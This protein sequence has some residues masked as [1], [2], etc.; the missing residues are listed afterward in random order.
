M[1]L[2]SE[3][4]EYF[5]T[6][7]IR[8]QANRGMLTPDM[9]TRIAMAVASWYRAQHGVMVSSTPRV[10]I[11]KDTRLSGYLLEPALTA[12][13]IAAGMDVMLLGPLP[14]SA[15]S[16]LVPSTRSTLGI[17]I[18][19]SHNPYRD[20]GIK[21]FGPRGHKL[22]TADECAI[23]AY[24]REPSLLY[25]APPD[26][27]GRAS[28]LEDARGRYIEMIKHRLPSGLRLDGLRIVLDA[29]HGASYHVGPQIL[30]ELGADVISAG[31]H[32]SGTN[33]NDY[34]GSTFPEKMQQMVKMHQADIGMALDGDA[35][36][37]IL[38][39]EEGEVIRGEEC[40][41]ALAVFFAGS[42]KPMERGV[43]TTILA[44]RALDAYLEP[45]GIPVL[46]VPVGDRPVAEAMRDRG[47]CLGGEPSGHMM[48][49]ADA[50]TGDGLLAGLQAVAMMQAY[51]KTASACL[52][53]FSLFPQI[54][55]HVSYDGGLNTEA[56][57]SIED[58]VR[59]GLPADSRVILRPSGTEPILR[60]TL[61]GKDRGILERTME[62]TV[63][64]LL[65]AMGRSLDG[66]GVD[67]D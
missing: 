49:D 23:E 11:A 48:F 21:I 50:A 41:G 57:K 44:N 17:M 29:A 43:V 35:D 5:G 18:S 32:P 52:H 51:G 15:V 10:L 62:E 66:K 20:N 65:H 24:I 3:R 60:I 19:A 12:G 16:L 63:A 54:S 4:P 33:I 31:V 14:T 28:R 6:D 55:G 40:L 26:A 37:I 67:V 22:S 45:Y 39:D 56:I 7:G 38:C 30:T 47:I 64:L 13:F 58:R 53:P 46:R 25:Y 9:A 2:L 34:C 42:G 61:E 59:E 8:G 27:L 36:R 1:P